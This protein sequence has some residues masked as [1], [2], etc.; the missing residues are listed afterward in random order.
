MVLYQPGTILTT[1]LT[2]NEHVV[3]DTD[4]ARIAST[5]TQAIANLGT[6]IPATNESTI[7]IDGTRTDSYTPNGTIIYPFK[8]FASAVT[9][10]AALAH[11]VVIYVA[12]ATYAEIGP[13]TFPNYP[14]VIYGNGSILNV[15]GDVSV[16]NP[17]LSRYNLFST[18]SGTLT[19]NNFSAGARCVINGGSITGNIVVNSYVEIS[20]CGLNGGIVTVNSGGQL[21]LDLITPTSTF[22]SAGTLIMERMNINTAKS[23]PLISITGG[24]FTLINSIVTNT[25]TGGGISI[26]SGQAGNFIASNTLSVASGA[27]VALS[28]GSFAVYSNNY[29]VSGTNTGTG[30]VG[31]N[32]DIVLSSVVQGTAAV[33]NAPTGYLGEIISNYVVSGAAV[34]VSSGTVTNITSISLTAGDWDVEG[35]INWAVAANTVVTVGNLFGGINTTSAT[36]PTDG[37]ACY[38]PFPAATYAAGVQS[39]TLPRKRI[40]VGTTTTVYLVSSGPVFTGGAISGYGGLSARRVR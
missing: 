24:T 12:P 14:C 37:T 21:V 1:N 38:T 6:S 39:V 33:G 32:S 23:I 25:G 17:N 20:Q 15:T 27:P 2:G 8:T 40:N 16:T 5:T 7:Y 26:T 9:A 13:I 18:I 11:A 29:I 10:W 28:A 19:Y 4:G 34:T 22:T 3:L 35:N 31:V 30:Y 36:I